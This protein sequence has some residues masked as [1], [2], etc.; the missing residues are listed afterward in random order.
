MITAGT[1]FLSESGT[2]LYGITILA[3]NSP[4]STP[5]G[6]AIVSEV[7]DFGPEVAVFNPFAILI[8]SYDPNLVPE[9]ASAES[10]SLAMFEAASNSWV[11][12]DSTVDPVAHK[13][14]GQIRHFTDFAIL[15]DTTP[16]AFTVADLT[17]IPEAVDIGELI[18]IKALVTNSGGLT[19]SYEVT[20]AIN[21]INNNVVVET[22]E[23]TLTGKTS[24]EV[25]FTV[26]RDVAGIYA[27]N[28]DGLAGTFEVRAAAP[29]VPPPSVPPVPAPAPQPSPVAGVSW[30]L[31]GGIIAGIIG[32]ALIIYL[33]RRRAYKLI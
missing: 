7:Y 32:V 31:I 11:L 1:T 16:A 21:D 14:K 10:L 2:P 4:A 29:S 25:I 3:Q 22:K 18:S 12:L 5:S 28:V 19:G 33:V 9:G 13:V 26:T 17:I 27:V 15:V 20:L 24:Q 23:V 30:Y 6:S 8:L